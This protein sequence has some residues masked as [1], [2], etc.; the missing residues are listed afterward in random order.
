VYVYTGQPD[1]P[2]DPAQQAPAHQL[3][4]QTSATE[5]DRLKKQKKSRTPT[6]IAGASERAS[7]AGCAARPS[8]GPVT[9]RRYLGFLANSWL[10]LYGA[11]RQHP[12]PSSEGLDHAGG[13][14]HRARCASRRWRRWAASSAPRPTTAESKRSSEIMARG[15][16]NYRG[17]V[18]VNRS[19][20]PSVNRSCLRLIQLLRI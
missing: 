6:P 13:G 16:R 4:G 7:P 10:V 12:I 1:K 9:V 11:G 18:S 14:D 17:S 20:S 3:R 19:P 8:A 2:T 15:D 5:K